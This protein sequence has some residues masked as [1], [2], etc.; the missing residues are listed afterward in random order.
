MADGG[1]D[2]TN[3]GVIFQPHEDQQLSGQGKLNIDGR[4]VRLVMV[5]ERLKRDGDPVQVLYAR[6]G[7][8]FPNT[9][10]DNERAPNLSGPIDDYAPQHKVAAW[11]GERD[12]RKYMSLRVSKKEPRNDGGQQGGGSSGPPRGNP[13]M[14]DEIPF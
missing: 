9:N 4:D 6:V 13:N 10:S 3:S 5:Y 11:R 1:Y 8:L 7:P 12:G 2:N 14:D